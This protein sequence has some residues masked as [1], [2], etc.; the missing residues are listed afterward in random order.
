VPEVGVSRGAPFSRGEFEEGARVNKLEL[1]ACHVHIVSLHYHFP[2]SMFP[3][4]LGA[5]VRRSSFF[6]I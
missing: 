1:D 6:F 3:Q 5:I 2:M 4:N